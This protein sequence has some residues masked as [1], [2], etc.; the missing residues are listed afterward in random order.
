M[1]ATHLRQPTIRSRQT[2]EKCVRPGRAAVTR[3]VRALVALVEH[4]RCHRRPSKTL[5][6]TFLYMRGAP[7]HNADQADCLA[8]GPAQEF[9]RRA[10]APQHDETIQQVLPVRGAS[11]R[12]RSCHCPNSLAADGASMPF[13]GLAK[14]LGAVGHCALTANALVIMPKTP[15]NASWVGY[16]KD[17]WAVWT[18][19]KTCFNMV[20]EQ[21]CLSW[22]SSSQA[23]CNFKYFLI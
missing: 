10:C 20:S 21:L 18:T 23:A 2:T 9:A 16:S 6:P 19:R 4:P 7:V 17:R 5:R 1:T 3:T 12:L 8:S 13:D 15:T 11:C 22:P 14:A